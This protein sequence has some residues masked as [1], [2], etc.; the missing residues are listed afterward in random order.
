VHA[1]EVDRSPG[2]H[3]GLRGHL[4]T[5]G[6]LAVTFGVLATKDV[7]LDVLEIKQVNEKIQGK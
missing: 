1:S 3:Q 2:S 7:H 4:A 5:E 6:T